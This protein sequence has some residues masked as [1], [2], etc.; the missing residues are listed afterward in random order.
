VQVPFALISDF[1]AES[2]SFRQ[3]ARHLHSI[4]LR[5]PS[6]RNDL[7][8]LRSGKAAEIVHLN[9]LDGLQAL[10]EILSSCISYSLAADASSIMHSKAYFSLRVRVP[11][12]KRAEDV[13]KL[14]VVAVPMTEKHT[15]LYMFQVT[16]RVMSVLDVAWMKKVVG[17]ASDGA[18]NM[19]GIDSGWQT[20]ERKACVGECA[21]TF[22][23][24]WC[25]NHQLDLVD[26]VAIAAMG[27]ADN[28]SESTWLSTLHAI[29]KF[30]RKQSSLIQDMGSKSPYCI[31]V[32]WSALG[33]VAEWYSPHRDNLVEYLANKDKGV[34]EDTTWRLQTAV[35]DN[36]F[37]AVCKPMGE[38]Q[39]KTTLVCD[40][41][42]LSIVF[43]MN[44]WTPTPYLLTHSF[45]MERCRTAAIQEMSIF[46]TLALRLGRTLWNL[47]P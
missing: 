43:M 31:N 28:D 10:R 44:S 36:H 35:L 17:V 3:A 8:P 25:G 34:G 26:K 29:V 40:K 23:R 22:F 13:S 16:G 30:L 39:G 38:I 14:H 41:T 12:R 19:T 47:S 42:Q 21:S 32:R 24:I 45:H 2:A 4:R 1:F 11:P 15:G 20:C 7:L 5:F 37:S 18:A 9:A 33:K 27:E 46:R 6:F